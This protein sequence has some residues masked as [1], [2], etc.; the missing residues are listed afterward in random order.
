MLFILSTFFVIKIFSYL[1]YF[2]FVVYNKY[3]VILVPNKINDYDK[4]I[5]QNW[6]LMFRDMRMLALPEN[7]AHASFCCGVRVAH[8][9]LFFL[10][11]LFDYLIFFVQCV[12]FSII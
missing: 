3:S 9:L 6:F 10:C 4:E 12:F 5:F 8:F 7:L 11:M 1:S 2:L